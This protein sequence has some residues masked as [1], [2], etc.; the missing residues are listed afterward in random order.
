MVQLR[1]RFKSQNPLIPTDSGICVRPRRRTSVH[2]PAPFCFVFL[3]VFLFVCF[4]N[5]SFSGGPTEREKDARAV[6]LCRPP[7][8]NNPETQEAI[9]HGDE[10]FCLP[11][12][13]FCF[14]ASDVTQ[15]QTQNFQFVLL[16]QTQSDPFTFVTY[17]MYV[18]VG[19]VR[20]S[21]SQ[22]RLT[23]MSQRLLLK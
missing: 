3:C 22:S 20:F 10:H 18:V 13:T 11:E 19:A 16:L 9:L 8:N 15:K 21:E 6:A 12:T 23:R 5:A 17:I 4:L 2:S 7:A 14:P 1:L